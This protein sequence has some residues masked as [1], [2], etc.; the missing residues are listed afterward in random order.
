MCCNAFGDGLTSFLVE[1]EVADCGGSCC[2]DREAET[3]E[4]SFYSFH[5]PKLQHPTR[6]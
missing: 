6:Q 5:F 1:V 2:E 3:A 4:E